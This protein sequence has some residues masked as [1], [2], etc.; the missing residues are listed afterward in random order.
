MVGILIDIM[1][2]ILDKIFPWGIKK[3]LPLVAVSP[4]K[5][6]SNTG[7][8]TA[9]YSFF[10][11]NK[12][13]KNL[14]DIY[15][16]LDG[17]HINSELIQIEKKNLRKEFDVQDK[18]IILNYEFTTFGLIDEN[19]NEITVIKI[20]EIDAHSTLTFQIKIKGEADIFLKVLSF[21]KEQSPVV[22]QDGK[23]S[24]PFY[25]PRKL[26][27]HNYRLINQ[28]VSLRRKK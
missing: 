22:F 18:D 24:V 1:L 28:K 11:K 21:S 9:Q 2:S 27:K 23:I 15:V 16:L 14:F 7:D 3:L 19:D 25:M 6:I 26:K 4:K 12:S 5:I 13:D 8:W 17:K 20:A 10:I